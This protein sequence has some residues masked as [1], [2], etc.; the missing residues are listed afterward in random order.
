[1][2][3]THSKALIGTRGPEIEFKN[4]G[5]HIDVLGQQLP[6]HQY[7]REKFVDALDAD[8]DF[9]EFGCLWEAV[10]T[11]GV[12]RALISDNGHGMSPDELKKFFG[13]IGEGKHEHGLGKHFHVGGRI[14]L[15]PWN[16]YGL[17][18]VTLK[19]DVLSTMWLRNDDDGK[20]YYPVQMSW[21]DEDGS[22]KTDYVV[23]ADVWS[24][25]DIKVLGFD[26][27]NVLHA[28]ALKVNHGTSF[29]LMGSEPTEHTLFGPADQHGRYD[30]RAYTRP[31]LNARIW[32]LPEGVRIRA[33]EFSS[34]DVE[35]WP[36][37]NTGTDLTK[38]IDGKRVEVGK[39]R[40]LKGAK[41]YVTYTSASGDKQVEASGTMTV[42]EDGTVIHWFMRDEAYDGDGILKKTKLQNGF[43]ATVNQNELFHVSDNY[44]DFYALGV[45]EKSVYDR[46]YVVFEPVDSVINGVAQ[47]TQRTALDWYTDG[48]KYDEALGDHMEIWFTHFR[49][50]LPR[51]IKDAVKAARAAHSVGASDDH[52][53]AKRFADKFAARW[54]KTRARVVASFS[55]PVVAD[56]TTS[57]TEGPLR[58]RRGRKPA[59]LCPECGKRVHAET[60]SLKPVVVTLTCE[61]CH[62]VGGH[63]PECSKH[64]KS[65]EKDPET[66][67]GSEPMTTGDPDTG[68]EPARKKTVEVGL[69][70]FDPVTEA[71]GEPWAI[72]E[73]LE[74]SGDDPATIRF[75]VAH[76]VIQ[77]QL[78][79]WATRFAGFVAEDPDNLKTLQ[80]TVIS[81]YGDM[82]VAR[83]GHSEALKGVIPGLTDEVLSG[84]ADGHMRSPAALT[85][86]VLG[87]IAEDAAIAP[88]I[89]GIAGRKSG[90]RRKPKAA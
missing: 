4:T 11:L 80:N 17:F 72:A 82:L 2:S 83:V 16:H 64:R 60:C 51:E 48:R 29:I 6:P 28:E 23:P 45:T 84:T 75:N 50:H 62:T 86:S 25:D 89:G 67:T 39:Y 13:G 12:Y 77:D 81:V 76:P 7:L 1:M 56:T 27:V 19:D 61:E 15:L 88:V 55:G 90:G 71:L 44:R 66:T 10:E 30:N 59:A 36:T 21:H 70:T 42:P 20:G 31:G 32:E 73:Y 9:I 18:I 47:N 54:T 43:L 3:E 58:V 38:I 87:L 34:S 53:R 78:E 85:M 41:H 79:Y 68:E 8:A 26:P 40:Y 69:P 14:S 63:T 49:N 37:E 22:I 65:P 74:A 46:T 5:A 57:P 52:E 24:E 35:R 33:V